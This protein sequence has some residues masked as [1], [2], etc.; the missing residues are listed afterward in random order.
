MQAIEMQDVKNEVR[1][2]TMHRVREERME[3]SLSERSRNR[4]QQGDQRSADTDPG[5]CMRSMPG[6]YV[7]THRHPSEAS[8][9]SPSP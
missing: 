1:V 6:K 9:S 2:E 7:S 4:C 8:K 3:G 5:L